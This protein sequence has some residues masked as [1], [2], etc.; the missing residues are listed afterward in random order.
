MRLPGLEE[1]FREQDKTKRAIVLLP[2]L[3]RIWN[4]D[5]AFLERSANLSSPLHDMLDMFGPRGG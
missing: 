2:L 1:A 3:H 5:F 4:W